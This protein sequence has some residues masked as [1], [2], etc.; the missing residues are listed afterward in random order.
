[1]S[2]SGATESSFI[3]GIAGATKVVNKSI[4]A[5]VTGWYRLLEGAATLAIAFVAAAAVAVF[6]EAVGVLEDTGYM[7]DEVVVMRQGTKDSRAIVSGGL[8]QYMAGLHTVEGAALV[9]LFGSVLGL[10][11]AMRG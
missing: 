10:S 9:E 5:V 1:M 4:L 8:G 2:E 11:P 7:D 3:S 6:C